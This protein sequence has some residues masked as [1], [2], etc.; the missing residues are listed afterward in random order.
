MEKR[1][2]KVLNYILGGILILMFGYAFFFAY[3]SHSLGCVYVKTHG[4]PCPTCGITRAFA[5]ILHLRFK[6]AVKLNMLSIPLFAFFF[7]QLIGRFCIN[8]FVL[9]HFPIKKVVLVDVVS[10]VILFGYCFYE[11]FS[12]L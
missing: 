2:Y 3:D 5:E 10:S 4:K 7:I 9:K 12:Y 11:L 6:E 8:F 1:D